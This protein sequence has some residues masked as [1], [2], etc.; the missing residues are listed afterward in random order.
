MANIYCALVHYPVR[1]RSGE[2]VATSVTNIDVHDIAR[3]CKT[4]GLKKHFIVTPIS[5]QR[6]IIDKITEH[7]KSG[8]GAKRIP[9]R[10][11][12][13]ELVQA[14]ETVELAVERIEEIEGMRPSLWTTTAEDHGSKSLNYPEARQR[15]AALQS[16]L[17]LL[18]G[19]GH[20]LANSLLD[21][22]DVILRP[23]VGAGEFN[24]LSVRAAVAI[25]LDRLL[26][27]PDHTSN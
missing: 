23:I 2:S 16:P 22:A 6:P 24:H 25:T 11:R 27:F 15:I 21:E 8:S 26:G 3:S 5:A 4:Y 12:A 20:G 19:T 13:I 9:E 17:L 14:I 1:D 10:S 7:W 18:F